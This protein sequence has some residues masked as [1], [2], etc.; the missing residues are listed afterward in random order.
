MEMYDMER[1]E[2]IKALVAAAENFKDILIDRCTKDYQ[3]MCKT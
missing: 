1:F 3:A 2:M